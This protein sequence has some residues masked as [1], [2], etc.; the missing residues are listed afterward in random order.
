VSN[1]SFFSVY[2]KRLFFWGLLEASPP[3]HKGWHFLLATFLLKW[4]KGVRYFLN[5]LLKKVTLKT[6][7]YFLILICILS[8]SC[9]TVNKAGY[10]ITTERKDNYYTVYCNDKLAYTIYSVN[11]SSYIRKVEYNGKKY[12]VS[13]NRKI[14]EININDI[15]PEDIA[16]SEFN[17]IVFE[18]TGFKTLAEYNL[19]LENQKRLEEEKKRQ[20]EKNKFLAQT[21]YRAF[22]LAGPY[23][24]DVSLIAV[25]LAIATAETKYLIEIDGKGYPQNPEMTK[26]GFDALYKL[27]LD[28]QKDLDKGTPANTV[29]NNLIRSLPNKKISFTW[30]EEWR[31]SLPMFYRDAIYFFENRWDKTGQKKK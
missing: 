3:A 7:N 18:K 2:S 22:D 26:E 25:A 9:A 6:L 24:P 29:M 12:F 16:V 4:Y 20:E 28:I 13:I 30:D 19:H 27:A 14:Y 10:K 23:G 21:K 17:K 15:L 1:E 31:D 11:N 5:C 8:L